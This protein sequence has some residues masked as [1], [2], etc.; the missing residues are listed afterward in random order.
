MIVRVIEQVGRPLAKPRVV[1]NTKVPCFDV[2]YLARRKRV[3]T[4]EHLSQHYG[5]MPPEWL[6]RSMNA[7]A[8]VLANIWHAA[9]MVA[10]AKLEGPVLYDYLR[11]C[12]QS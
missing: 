4:H 8:E 11:G 7:E 2:H 12:V 10:Y 1:F 6:V 9:D 3:M 5:H